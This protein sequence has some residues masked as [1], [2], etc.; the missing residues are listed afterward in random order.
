MAVSFGWL[1]SCR[2]PSKCKRPR[3]ENILLRFFVDNQY[4]RFPR[5]K[6]V[7]MGISADDFC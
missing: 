3:G 5:E 4:G 7:E 6:E 2:S 1:A